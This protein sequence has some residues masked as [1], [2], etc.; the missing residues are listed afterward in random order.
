MLSYRTF[1]QENIRITQYAKLFVVILLWV[2]LPRDAI[3]SDSDIVSTCI[4]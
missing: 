2:V 3:M 4:G 1:K